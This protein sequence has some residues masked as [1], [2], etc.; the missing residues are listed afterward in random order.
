MDQGKHKATLRKKK[1]NFQSHISE[2]GSE[3]WICRLNRIG[4]HMDM[5]LSN[6]TARYSECS[7]YRYFLYRNMYFI[8]CILLINTETSFLGKINGKHPNLLSKLMN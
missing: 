3:C 8:K 4:F 2:L 6:Q 7:K 5:D 1:T